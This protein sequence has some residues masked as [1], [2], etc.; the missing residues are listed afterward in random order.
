M[1][2]FGHTVFRMA[3]KNTSVASPITLKCGLTL[4]NR[5]IK[6]AMAEH[7]VGLDTLPN[8]ALISSYGPWAEGGWGMVM[9]GMWE[10]R[11]IYSRLHLN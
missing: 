4:P 6:A 7:E 2:C 3:V 8:D 11:T 1:L 10:R 5:L 9:T